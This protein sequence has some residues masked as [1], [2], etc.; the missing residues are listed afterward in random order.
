MLQAL[1]AFAGLCVGAT[2]LG[3][4]SAWER[5]GPWNI[6]DDKFNNGESGTLACAASPE[7]NP[8]IIYAGGQNNGV[9]SGILKSVN[10]GMNCT[11]SGVD[12]KLCL[13]FGTQSAGSRC[14]SSVQAV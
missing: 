6:F 14:I 9:S 8:H 13:R 11:L 7:Q 3:N 4:G 12:E 1:L 5:V 2:A 10:G